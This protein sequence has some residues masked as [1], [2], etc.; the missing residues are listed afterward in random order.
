MMRFYTGD[1]ISDLIRTLQSIKYLKLRNPILA[2]YLL[3]V[4]Y[5]K[6]YEI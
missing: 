3:Y 1:F 2:S 5:R 6:R 4:F